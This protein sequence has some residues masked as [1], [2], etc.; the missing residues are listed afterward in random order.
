MNVIFHIDDIEK[1][2]IMIS[3]VK[4]FRK[5]IPNGKI[6]VLVNGEAVESLMIHSPVTISV[7]TELPEVEIVVCQ[8]SLNQ[9]KIINEDLQPQLMKVSSG[10]VELVQKQVGGYVYIKP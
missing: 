5:E 3:N 4:N 6:E 1:W 9:R 7:L 8:N 10:V 2:P